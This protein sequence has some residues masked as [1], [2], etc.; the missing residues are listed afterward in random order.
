MSRIQVVSPYR[1]FEPE[2]REHVRLGPFD[3][4]AALRMLAVS[5]ERYSQC[6]TY[7][8]TDVDTHLPVPTWQFETTERRL[9]LWILDVT[10]QFLGSPHFDRD[11][12]MICPDLLV[13]GDLEPFFMAD[14]G[15]IVRLQEK[16]ADRP[17]LNS[18]Q[19]F[20]HS[21]KKKLLRFYDEAIAI[22]KTL[23]DEV[24][25]WGADS[26]P[27]RQLV[28]PLGAGVRRRAGLKVALLPSQWVLDTF[29]TRMR[30]QL[31]N[32][33]TPDVPTLPILDFRYTRKHSMQA[34]FDATIG[35]AVPA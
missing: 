10:R 2:S 24:I 12:V 23:P 29:D 20:R 6:P 5:V 17:M 9:M 19:W 18:V 1:P 26:E 30:E 16:H 34:Y 7:A 25:A 22:A 27:L 31:E 3:W 14:L 33:L 21:G 15:L 28:V 8:I 4:I 11:T 35:E 32:G 13:F